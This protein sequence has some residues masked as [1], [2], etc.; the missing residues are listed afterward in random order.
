V[1]PKIST[2]SIRTHT[3]TQYQHHSTPHA[4]KVH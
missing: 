3:N 4:H 2:R 1:A